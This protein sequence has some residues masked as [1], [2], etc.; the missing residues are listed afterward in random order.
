MQKSKL[1]FGRTKAFDR[2]KA[3]PA[4]FC[5]AT[6]PAETLWEETESNLET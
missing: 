6:L 3:V 1:N 4:Q 5:E 2:A